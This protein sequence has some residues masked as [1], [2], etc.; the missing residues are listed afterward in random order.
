MKSRKKSLLTSALLG[1][2]ALALAACGSPTGPSAGSGVPGAVPLIA[3]DDAIAALVPQQIRDRGTLILATEAANP[4]HVFFDADGT[5]IIGN[6]VEFGHQIGSI[7]GLKVEWVNTTF[8]SI[9]TGLQAGRYDAAISAMR[10]TKEREEVVDFVAYGQGGQQLFAKK[11]NVDLI[12]SPE[13]LCGY[14]FA[15]QSGTSL[16]QQAAE[17]SDQCVAA[18]RPAI[19]VRVFKGK[20]DQVQA[21]ASGQVMFAAQKESLNAYMARQTEGALVGFGKP[22]FRYLVGIP[23][24][25]DSGMTQ[26]I[27][28]AVQKLIASPQYLQ[29]LQNWELTS[30]A[31]SEPKLNGATE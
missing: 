14:S 28:Q 11:E 4:P 21:V 18:G 20:S 24:A 23:I 29:I 19:D 25:K 16:E 13:Q 9:L 1:A 17:Y 2:C 6:E 15:V 5:T 22:F 3:K 27:F 31:I 8:D 7:L 30:Q 10:D 12:S 26:P